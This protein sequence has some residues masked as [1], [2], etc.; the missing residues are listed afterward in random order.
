MLRITS[1][2]F[3]PDL[4]HMKRKKSETRLVREAQ[5]PIASQSASLKLLYEPPTVA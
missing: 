3:T 4:Y 2:R 5:T 1:I